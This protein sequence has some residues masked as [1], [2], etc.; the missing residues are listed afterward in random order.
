MDVRRF[1][2]SGNCMAV[3]GRLRPARA[4]YPLHIWVGLLNF[5]RAWMVA[6]PSK[7]LLEVGERC[8][9]DTICAF[10]L[11][12][13]AGARIRHDTSSPAEEATEWVIGV[14]SAVWPSTV[15]VPS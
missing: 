7:S 9:R 13:S 10:C 2:N 12:T 5:R 6:L 3:N 1:S 8:F 14:G 4:V 11:R 15:F